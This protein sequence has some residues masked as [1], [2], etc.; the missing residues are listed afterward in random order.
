LFIAKT[1]MG[2]AVLPYMILLTGFTLAA[3]AVGRLVKGRSVLLALRS[4]TSRAVIVSLVIAVV[5]FVLLFTT[6]FTNPAGLIT[7]AFGSIS[8][9]LAQHGVQRGA[10]PWYYYILLLL[11]LYEFLPF[12][13]SLMG[14][15]YYLLKGGAGRK[16]T[17]PFVPF[18][19]YWLMVSVLI[20]SWIGEKMPWM[21]VH[22]ALPMILLSGR[23]IGDVLEG[24]NWKEVWQRGGAIFAL[25][26]VL[27][28]FAG[29]TL[30]RVTPF[31]GMSLY[32]L[33]ATGQWLGA[34]VT[35]L[36]LGYF[37]IHYLRLLGARRS[38]LVAFVALSVFLSLL[39]VRFAWM[40]SFINYDN[41]KE[42]LV[43]AHGASDVKMVMKEIEGLS[44][45]TVGDRQIKVAYDDDSTW[46]FEWYLRDYPN[47]AYYGSQPTKE[48]LDAPVV[49][50][51]PKN[52]Q[53]ARPFLGDR[54]HRFNYRLVWWPIEDY[55]DLTPRKLL[56]WL[57][58]PAER[59]KWWNIAFY[60]RYE[61]PLNQWPFVHRFYFYVR[62]DVA[63]KLWDYRAGPVAVE[64]LEGPYAKGRLKVASILT[65]GSRGN[66][67][68]Q[69]VDPRGLAVDKEGNIY[70]ADGGNHRIQKFDAS[71]KVLL[72]WGSQ[73][74]G[75][76]QFQEPWGIAVDEEG[77]VYVADTWNHRIQ[78]FDS[79]GR[80]LTQ[81][82]VFGNTDGT[83]GTGGVFWG[84]RGIAV[85]EKGNIYVTDTGNKRVQKFTSEGEFL[86][87]WG[88]LGSEPGKFDEPVGIAIDEE[89]CIYVADAW[90]RRVQKFDKGF[91][92]VTEWPIHGW[93]S[94]SVINKPCLAAGGG[95]VYAT[96]PE[97]YRVLV[98][99][100]DGKF[101]A[102]FGEYG[103]D[104]NS[105]GLPIGVGVD[106][107]GDSYV[108]DSGNNRVMKFGPIG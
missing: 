16:E 85:D 69:F 79:E 47:R 71:G 46:P 108:V 107:E 58:D 40:A 59:E 45:R 75:P 98:F 80:F 88:G 39:T 66:G 49:I 97:G 12:L 35:V 48:A 43:Y 51:G 92:F 30:L 18:L 95:R 8:Y 65:W 78:K 94:Q 68:G 87:Q 20:Y 70:V 90:N 6:F 42:F 54:Y 1:S 14:M 53:K 34:L 74:N 2:K 67:P 5:I 9:W 96:D 7:G 15:G 83:L 28:L 57:R 60:R 33:G 61:T 82:G 91:N 101:L 32:K 55:K 103:L 50:V 26:L 13:L 104:E 84:P 73:G 17:T 25:L 72:Q 105:F 19:A 89:G 41:A 100:S 24:V 44:R 56:A 64:E 3:L 77:S 99:D 81:W 76:G 63:A 93:E 102:T 10:Q 36:I 62:K 106:A 86:G 29:S 38:L 11:P 21:V 27:I 52:E 22:L 4:I 31:Q 23:F 37:L